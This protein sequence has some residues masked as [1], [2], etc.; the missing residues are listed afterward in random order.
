M[1]HLL[2]TQS[3]AADA[4][5]L[6]IFT[7]CLTLTKPDDVATTEFKFK[8]KDLAKYFAELIAGATGRLEK[9]KDYRVVFIWTPSKKTGFYVVVQNEEAAQKMRALMAKVEK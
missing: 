6:F 9:T 2:K 7:S 8:N 1:P 5:S 3:A 4:A